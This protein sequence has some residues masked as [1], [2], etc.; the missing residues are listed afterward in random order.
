M[1]HHVFVLL[2]ASLGLAQVIEPV[3][4]PFR[5]DGA[6]LW[7][8]AVEDDRGVVLS[9]EREGTL[10][11]ARFDPAKADARPQWKTVLAPKDLGGRRIA[12]HGHIWAH[13][14]HYFAVSVT[15]ADRSAL[16]VLDGDFERLALCPVANQ[17]ALEKPAGPAR[18]MPT[19]DMFLVAEPEGVAV[20]HFLPG[21]GHRVF[22]CSVEG[23]V[24]ATVDVGGR[25]ARHSNGSS[26]KPS[27]GGGYTIYATESLMSLAQS[28]ILE[29]A[30]DADWKVQRCTRLVDES[31]PTN[32]AMPSAVELDGGR[33]MLVVWRRDDAWP[34]GE[35]PP[36]KPPAGVDPDKGSI[37]RYV[38][39]AD[40]SVE[41]S[42]LLA[43]GEQR[44]FRP[45]ATR[46]G[47]LLIT[48]WDAAGGVYLQ[49]DNLV[50]P[51]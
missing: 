20:G 6:N 19:N 44:P 5:L 31:A 43:D 16:L 45:H 28:A 30:V 18:T 50:R 2:L 51:K 26:A 38:L 39:A 3:R 49:L 14:R 12:D 48:C 1:R 17:V 21:F 36:P 23:E 13:G 24:W 37:F 11:V 22:R 29:I 15:E 42:Q 25:E 46:V 47:D 7:L 35:L 40:G 32:L 4:A 41:S 34:R 27:P 10:V 8:F 9:A 33:R